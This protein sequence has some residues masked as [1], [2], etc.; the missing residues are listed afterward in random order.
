MRDGWGEFFAAKLRLMGIHPQ[1]ERWVF[2]C[3]AQQQLAAYEDEKMV[4]AFPCSTGAK[5][6]GSAYG[7]GG[8]PLGLHTIATK[9]GEGAPR[10]MIFEKR[11]PTGKI[12]TGAEEKTLITTRIL[13]L[14]GMEKD[15][16]LGYACGSENRKIYIHGVS[17]E[18]NIGKP[19]SEGCVNLKNAD[20]VKLFDWVREGD[21]V[22][23]D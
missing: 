3:L 16:N 17:K 21:L 8:T 19:V 23:I 9:I 1:Q 7:S 20:V 12:A 10:G 13:W 2:V 6:P 5:P 11:E 14:A 15:K 4:M 18:E 22:L